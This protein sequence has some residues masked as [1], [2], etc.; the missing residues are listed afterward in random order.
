MRRLQS[1]V[2]T[3]ILRLVLLAVPVLLLSCDSGGS[4]GDEGNSGSDSF[5]LSD[6]TFSATV[7]DDGSDNNVSGNAV[8]GIATDIDPGN[9]DIAERD[10]EAFIIYLLDGQKSLDDDG[11]VQIDGTEIIL[12]REGSSSPG[13]GSISLDRWS[14]SSRDLRLGAG[15][16]GGSVE[17]TSAGDGTLEGTFSV[18][19]A[20][21]GTSIQGSFT[22]QRADDIDRVVCAPACNDS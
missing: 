6:G 22:A 17:I 14:L 20:L 18:E 21:G 12:S 2:S 13:T 1:S 10:G 7:T 15:S 4:N 3:F 8:F 5:S 11:E 9:D 16:S 19:S